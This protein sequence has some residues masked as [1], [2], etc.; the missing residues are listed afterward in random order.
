MQ[1]AGWDNAT[2]PAP[3]ARGRTRRAVVHHF[4]PPPD[5]DP[6]CRWRYKRA[7][8]WT[9]PEIS[10]LSG[11]VRRGTPLTLPSGELLFS[12]IVRVRSDRSVMLMLM[13]DIGSRARCAS[14]LAARLRVA[15]VREA[16]LGQDLH[17]FA[18]SGYRLFAVNLATGAET[19]LGFV[20]SEGPLTL[21]GVELE[22]SD[23][24]IRM[25]ADGCYW[26]DARYAT[27][28]P[29]TIEGGEIAVPLP[30][31]TG[32][33]Y[34]RG[35]DTALISWTWLAAAGT[36][37]PEDFAIWAGASQPVDTSG[38]PAQVVSSRAPGGYTT[39]IPDAADPF[40]VAVRA[41]RDGRQGPVS[42]IFI[43]APEVF[44]DSP[45]NQTAWLENRP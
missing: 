37:A 25:R 9:P 3:L 5:Y 40:Y 10:T 15:G 32:L 23:Y 11:R 30:A 7:T 45:D 24:E 18:R 19:S 14:L 26:R 16:V 21:T 44:I 20:P 31:V 27:V 28:F 8:H 35:N 43:P 34:S 6:V 36:Q 4:S 29:L 39:A 13:Q 2:L 1:I 42:T 12:Q 17:A 38:D 41:R 33:R 22:D